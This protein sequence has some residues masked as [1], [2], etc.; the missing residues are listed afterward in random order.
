[1]IGLNLESVRA[2]LELTKGEVM[3]LGYSHISRSG[4]KVVS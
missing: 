4:N 1:V 3:Y 2:D